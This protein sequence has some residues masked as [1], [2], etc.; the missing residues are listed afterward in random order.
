MNFDQLKN[1]YIYPTRLIKLRFRYRIQ[2]SQTKVLSFSLNIKYIQ[3]GQLTVYDFIDSIMEELLSPFLLLQS[4]TV[5]W[6]TLSIIYPLKKGAKC[7]L[8]KL[9]LFGLK[10]RVPY[11][12]E[13]SSIK[14]LQISIRFQGR[15]LPTNI[16]VF[17][18]DPHAS[19]DLQKLVETCGLIYT[20]LFF[21]KNTGISYNL[22]FQASKKQKNTDLLIPIMA[23]SNIT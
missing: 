12:G 3:S 18:I 13:S 15:P 11:I 6:E 4:D 21:I 8:L 7:D 20:N 19:D 1:I 9:P 2:N 10:G 16:K 5:L 22:V 14:M 17:G 23:F